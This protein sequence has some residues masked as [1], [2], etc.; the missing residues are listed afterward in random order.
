M[1]P[2]SVNHDLEMALL[3]PFQMNSMGLRCEEYDRRNTSLIPSELAYDDIVADL[4]VLMLSC[5][6][7]AEASLLAALTA[8][9]KSQTSATFDSSGNMMDDVSLTA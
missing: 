8:P 1:W 9:R 4:C 2:W 6:T 3:T 5:T 7:M